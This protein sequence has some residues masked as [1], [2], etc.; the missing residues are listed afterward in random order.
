MALMALRVFSLVARLIMGMHPS[1]C[2]AFAC[3][4][5]F[6]DAL[7]C[8]LPSGGAAVS[9]HINRTKVLC[10]KVLGVCVWWLAWI[11]PEGRP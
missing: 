9:N 7:M 1:V 10:V 11:V 2:A 3:E 6:P 5:P 4:C 8:C